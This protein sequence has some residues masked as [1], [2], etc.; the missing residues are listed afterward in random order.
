LPKGRLK[1][2]KRKLIILLAAGALMLMM[3]ATAAFADNL[4]CQVGIAC[5]GTPTSD[6]MTGTTSDDQIKGFGGK[7]RINDNGG[8]DIDT[9]A[10]GGEND[11]IDVQENNSGSN[12]RDLV[13]C[14]K[15]EKDRVFFDTGV[16]GDRVVRCE[17]KNP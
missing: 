17:I 12:N 8:M 5:N 16:N 2:I 4:L 13:D 6:L 14:G 1:I 15:G 9:I 7:D 10:G 3:A 11:T